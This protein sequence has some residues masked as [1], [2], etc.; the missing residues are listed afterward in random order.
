MHILKVPKG[1]NLITNRVMSKVKNLEEGV[2]LVKA[3]IAQ[4][5][6]EDRKGWLENRLRGLFTSG[7]ENPSVIDHHFLI[8]FGKR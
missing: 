6:H 5:G 3:R 1:G 4:H 2:N 8:S 7:N